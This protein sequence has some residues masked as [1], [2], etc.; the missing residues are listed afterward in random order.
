MWAVLEKK[1]ERTLSEGI[2]DIQKKFNFQN[3][4]E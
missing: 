3:L 2:K 4:K 1:L